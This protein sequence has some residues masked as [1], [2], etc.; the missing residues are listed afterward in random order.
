MYQFSLL[1]SALLSFSLIQIIFII[2]LLRQEPLRGAKELGY[3]ILS[4]SFYTIGTSFEYMG[5]SLKQIMFWAHVQYI[6][7]SWLPLF[8]VHFALVY[9]NITIGYKKAIYWCMAFFSTLFMSLQ[10]TYNFHS[11]FYTDVIFNRI[12]NIAYLTFTPTLFYFLIKVY[13]GMAILVIYFLSGQMVLSGNREYQRR[14]ALLMLAT[15]FP[16]IGTIIYLMPI[17][18]ARIDFIPFTFIISSTILLYSYLKDSLFGPL[19]VAKRYIFESLDD[20]I[21]IL[22][23]EDC[24]IDFNLASLRYVPELNEIQI[25]SSIQ[26][27]FRKSKVYSTLASSNFYDSG[28]WDFTI[29]KEGSFSSSFYEIRVLPIHQGPTKGSSLLI[30][31]VSESHL[32]QK[33]LQESYDRLVELDNLKTM[34]IEVMSHDLRSPL[35][36]MR[37]LRRLMASGALAKN[38]VIWKRSGDELDSLIDR[39]DS[40][41]FN[42]LSLTS[43]FDSSE[44]LDLKVFTLQSILQHIEESVLR[45]SR[46]KEVEFEQHIEDDVLLVGSLDY[47]RAIFRN[48]IE[49]AIKYSPRK[50]RVVLTVDIEKEDIIVTVTDEGDGIPVQVLQAFEQDRWGVTTMGTNGEKGPGIGLYA[51]KRFIQAQHGKL[52]IRKNSPM[53]TIIDFTIPR[54][55]ETKSGN[56]DD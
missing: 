52:N 48:I 56:E 35:V 38:P 47:A 24:V 8:L 51:T 31:D 43:S 50:G 9:F 26:D 21:I 13:Q 39:A 40:L 1:A 33:A 46:K 4:F 18:E 25:G 49:N 19:P 41:I 28:V 12:G 5:T 27:V 15:A 10:F 55:K 16:A 2:I 32:L 29:E 23:K 11:L 45:Y 30:R 44:S 17:F 22:D 7:L 53:G 34:V 36:T 42:L 14:G 54:S 20:G 37:G 3:V 6:G